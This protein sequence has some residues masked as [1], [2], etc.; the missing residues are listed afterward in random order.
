MRFRRTIRHCSRPRPSC[1]Q[2]LRCWLVCSRPD[3]L[4]TLIRFR[5]CAQNDVSVNDLRFALRQLRKSPGFAFVAVLTLAL[6][7]GA[8]VVV[9]GVVNAALLRPLDVSDPQNLYQLRIGPWTNWKLLKPSYPAFE[10]IR[11]RS[12]T[13]SGMAGFDG[14]AEA[15]LRWGN[16]V[17][18]VTGYAVTGK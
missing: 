2:Q 17:K 6:G 3:E 10:D 8:N 15:T 5:R 7:I 4:H 14:L 12:S 18:S 1:L 9:F 13:F 16:T 11:Q